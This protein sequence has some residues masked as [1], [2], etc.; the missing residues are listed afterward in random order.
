[1]EKV[2]LCFSD[3]SSAELP[4]NFMLQPTLDFS[5]N[6]QTLRYFI[7]PYSICT[8]GFF[9]GIKAAHGAK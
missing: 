5:F 8:G 6:L 7:V 9:L 4:R 2:Q 3:A 1:M